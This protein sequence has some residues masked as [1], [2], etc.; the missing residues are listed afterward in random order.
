MSEKKKLI[1]EFRFP[2]F[3]SNGEW[4][5]EPLDKIAT[6]IKE[7]TKG[8]KFKLMSIS[9][10]EG[11]VSQ[12]ERFGREIAGNSYKNYYVINRQDFAYNKSS[13]KLY[14]EGEIAMLE[15]EKQAAVPNSVF[16]CFRFNKGLII[17]EFAKFPFE[18]NLHGRWLRKFIAVGARAHGAL[19]VKINDFFSI[20][21]PLPSIPEQKKIASCLTTLDELISSHRDKV[22]ALKDHKKWLMQNLFPQEG[23]KVP[24]YRFT[25]FKNNGEWEEKN[26][27]DVGEFVGG[28]TPSTSTP[29][30]WGGDIQWYTPSEVKSRK[31][32]PS[33]RTITEKGLKNSSA[34]LLPIDTI[35]ITTRA[36]IGEVAI[37]NRECSTNQGFQSLIV[38]KSEITLFW[39]YWLLSHKHELDRRSSGSTFK[40]I[41]KNKIKVIP[42][43][44]PKK[45]E[46]KKVAYCL[47]ALDDIIT[48]QVEKVEQLK[49]HKMGLI[50]GLFPKI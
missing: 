6:E 37:T 12:I 14:P 8:R 24:K 31:L 48:E 22:E 50:Q 13:T 25:E 47:S 38:K 44:S 4:T 15:S 17:P 32:K 9:S 20:P 2:E 42:T 7:K 35:L 29:E 41:G 49:L 3:V 1:P 26:L 34:K 40:E 18:N 28:G 27:G 16:I 33:I 39:Y 43:L 23:E 5:T 19:Q 21:F 36:T 10:G 11:L 30:Y 45:E 46:Q